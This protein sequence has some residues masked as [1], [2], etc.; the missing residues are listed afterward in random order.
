MI[1]GYL[2]DLLIKIRGLVGKSVESVIIFVHMICSQ[3]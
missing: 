3:K 2:Y 1:H